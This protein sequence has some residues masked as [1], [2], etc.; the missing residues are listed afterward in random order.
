MQTV[1]QLWN[2]V[3]SSGL[4][5]QADQAAVRK[6]WFQGSRAELGDAD[7]FGRWLIVNDFLTEF[8]LRFLHAGRG[9]LLRFG[10]YQIVDQL[11]RGPLAGAYLGLD[12]LR[13]RVLIEVLAENHA[14][15][16]ATLQA[17][18]KVAQE[19]LLVDQA[20]LNRLVDL[21]QVH[22]LHYIVREHDEGELLADILTRRQHLAPL[23]AARLFA[24]AL[25]ALQALHDHQL[26]GGALG[27]DCFL[28]TSAGRNT[29]GVK[30]RTLKLLHWGFPRRLFDAAALQRRAGLVEPA[31]PVGENLPDVDW[32]QFRPANDLL[33]LGATFYQSLTGK[34]PQ[35]PVR[36]VAEANPEVPEMLA[37][38]VD[39][40]LAADSSQRPRTAG[41]AAKRLRIILA[42]EEENREHNPEEHLTAVNEPE[43]RTSTIPAETPSSSPSPTPSTGKLAELW[44]EL[45]PG[46][47]DLFFLGAGAAAII[48]LTLLARLLFGFTFVNVVCLVT[49]AALSYLVERWLRLRETEG[50]VL[51]EEATHSES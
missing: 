21:G 39:Q 16:P 3:Q 34:R 38:V 31:T 20:N 41:Q 33:H 29:Q 7:K 50:A 30:L 51:N 19:A 11:Q 36:P 4:L 40:L 12:A 22:G 9:D 28:L 24:L 44:Q 26:S 8:S 47:R 35:E 1:E 43:R 15:Q 42:S 49:G 6:K 2:V 25:A 48:L 13:R 23:P 14:N 5:T 45:R 32:Q 27:I 37:D 10:Q 17:V 46:T 18:Q